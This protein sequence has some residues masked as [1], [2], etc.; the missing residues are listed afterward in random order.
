MTYRQGSTGST[1]RHALTRRFDAL[2]T[3]FGHDAFISYARA[4]ALDYALRLQSKLK[5]HKL[6][7]FVDR[8][9][10]NPNKTTSEDVKR[11]IRTSRSLVIIASPEALKNKN[12]DD[13]IR[14]FPVHLRPV[15]I[16]DVNGNA[17]TAKW[18]GL[19]EGATRPRESLAALEAGIPSSE[20]ISGISRSS[21]FLRS[22]SRLM[23]AWASAICAIA[24]TLI[25]VFLSAT[26]L[27]ESERKRTENEKQLL[28]TSE[29]LSS[30]KNAV[31]AAERR[32]EIA[33]GKLT[34]I[35]TEL[36]SATN[37]LNT[38][39][40]EMRATAYF[41]AAMRS[42][43]QT[44]V[45]KLELAVAGC[46]VAP[47]DLCRQALA[48][49]MHRYIPEGSIQLGSSSALSVGSGRDGDIRVVDE[50]GVVSF[51]NRGPAKGRRIYKAPRRVE[52]ADLS[53]DG[54]SAL[55]FL[56]ALGT[57]YVNLDSGAETPLGDGYFWPS[58]NSEWAIQN[59]RLPGVRLWNVRTGELA[60][61]FL[62]LE[63]LENYEGRRTF[64]YPQHAAISPDN[65]W[66]LTVFNVNE[67][68]EVSVRPLS[69]EFKPILLLSSQE[70]I[71]LAEFSPDS[72]RVVVVAGKTTQLFEASGK[73]IK[74]AS[75]ICEGHAV[76]SQDWTALACLGP[77]GSY[78]IQRLPELEPVGGGTITFGGPGEAPI[79]SVGRD[80]VL[81]ARK[82]G[83]AEIR[84]FDGTRIDELS[85]QGILRSAQFIGTGPDIVT[86][87][88]HDTHVEI[89]RPGKSD[90]LWST[91]GMKTRQQ[92]GFRPVAHND[93]G[94][95]FVD[96][97][98][99]VLSQVG[100][101]GCRVLNRNNDL[102]F[103]LPGRISK[104]R[105]IRD[106]TQLAISG[107][108]IK[109]LPNSPVMHTAV[110]DGTTGDVLQGPFPGEVFF[111]P[112][113]DR[114]L[115]HDT[116]H[117]TKVLDSN[118][119]RSLASFKADDADLAVSRDAISLVDKGKGHQVIRSLRSG[120]HIQSFNRVWPVY[121]IS[122]SEDYLVVG[123]WGEGR[124][125]DLRST[126]APPK[127]F[128]GVRTNA[129][130]CFLQPEGKVAVVF[131][132]GKT[133]LK[134]WFDFIDLSSAKILKS[135]VVEG[136]S[137]HPVCSPTKAQFL[138]TTEKGTVVLEGLSDQPRLEIIPETGKAF[139]SAVFGAR[140][141]S[142]LLS[143][144]IGY[145]A[146]KVP[147]GTLISI[148]SKEST[149][150]F[151]PESGYLTATWEKHVTAF[152]DVASI[153]IGSKIREAKERL[154][155]SEPNVFSAVDSDRFA[156]RSLP[157]M[158]ALLEIP[159]DPLIEFG[160]S[161]TGPPKP[162]A[163][164]ILIPDEP[165]IHRRTRRSQP[166]Q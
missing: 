81:L 47:S 113:V 25:L 161:I 21:H 117:G 166:Y 84:R 86:V 134:H 74:Q 141:E 157:A 16:V 153:P 64:A 142:I 22:N 6:Q 93:H 37:A 130:L 143:S 31:I 46:D 120:R 160:L 45:R 138:F 10:T 128:E 119:M 77:N 27:S 133:L 38:A 135:I 9:S 35:E 137:A 17:H 44:T 165:V 132:P 80:H 144:G 57:V 96:C 163:T 145:E 87:S 100:N 108:E 71:L 43:G 90:V 103:N 102:L 42:T 73:L 114:L 20:T 122:P 78:S 1:F 115:I 54:S 75:T 146:W 156:P 68:W 53:R 85:H 13:E 131:R 154:R 152:G 126:Q 101:V 62:P 151:D 124:I 51:F 107:F 116:T 23:I 4:D 3:F 129:Q 94:T 18:F 127:R 19:V 41:Q 98:K 150:A 33:E 24:V 140:G 91:S 69:A 40:S 112:V 147:E 82:N 8:L 121:R 72:K 56:E 149:G 105:F 111:H 61:Y 63:P 7:A 88:Y 34:D 99:S 136:H 36:S 67:G 164:Q 97:G 49:V 48:R 5:R 59:T 29:Q 76:T 92:A 12:V 32:L 50:E 60:A 30:R 58:S 14:T 106:G 2:R 65:N 110:L 139:G 123:A 158:P 55:L 83:V 118:S 28:S 109:S 52:T 26:K 66:A 162:A 148:L 11:R 125:Y 155:Y 70:R 159:A 89:W 104:A 15:Q 95:R 79:I 39:N